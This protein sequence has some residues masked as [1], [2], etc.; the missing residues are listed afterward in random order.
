MYPPYALAMC[1]VMMLL[2]LLLLLLLLFV[3]VGGEKIMTTLLVQFLHTEIQITSDKIDRM[4]V[5]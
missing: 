5:P 2:L 1:R 4:N 3:V